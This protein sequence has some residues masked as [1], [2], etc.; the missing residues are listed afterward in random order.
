MVAVLLSCLHLPPLHI[1]FQ[2]NNGLILNC[3][4][5]ISEYLD[6]GRNKL[7]PAFLTSFVSS[8]DKKLS[9]KSDDK[10][11]K[12]SPT[13]SKPLTHGDKEHVVAREEF[14]GTTCAVDMNKVASEDAALEQPGDSLDSPTDLKPREY[15]CSMYETIFKPFR[16]EYSQTTVVCE[17]LSWTHDPMNI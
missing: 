5:I 4:F 12:I 3:L 8:D 17:E 7:S 15:H 6:P 14:P 1:H 2:F 11:S 13:L 10:G 16:S 9:A